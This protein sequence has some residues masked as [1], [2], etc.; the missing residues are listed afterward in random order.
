[1]PRGPQPAWTVKDCSQ[2]HV[3]AAAIAAG[4]PIQYTGIADPD[5][6]ADIRRGIYRCGI[7]RKI[8]VQVSWDYSGERA[9][10]VQFWPPDKEPDGTYALWVAVFKKSHGRAHVVATRGPDRSQWDYNP[11]ERAT[12]V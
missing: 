7:H 11:R 6:A 5:R 2:D 3:V 1:M 12:D 4:G 8:S 10:R 9:S